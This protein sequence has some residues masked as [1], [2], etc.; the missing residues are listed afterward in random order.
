[1][2][3]LCVLA[4]AGSKPSKLFQAEDLRKRKLSDIEVDEEDDPVCNALA[5]QQNRRQRRTEKSAFEGIFT[6]PKQS[7]VGVDY[8]LQDPYDAK[9]FHH[10]YCYQVKNMRLRRSRLGKG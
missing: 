7:A 4:C 3:V 2:K 8:D 9:F 6:K 1:M 10:K 5:A